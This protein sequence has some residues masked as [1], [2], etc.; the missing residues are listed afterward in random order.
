MSAVFLLIIKACA[1]VFLCVLFLV[2]IIVCSMV[3]DKAKTGRNRY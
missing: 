1:A 3:D 2:S